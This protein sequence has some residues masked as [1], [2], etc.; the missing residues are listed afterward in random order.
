ME[1]IKP[2]EAEQVRLKKKNGKK[3]AEHVFT[4]VCITLCVILLPLFFVNLILTVKG[5][6]NQDEV[7]SLFSIAPM[8]VLT[9]SMVP[10]IDGG[11]L[12]F[13]KKVNPEDIVVDDIIAFFDPES[14][15]STMVVH[16]VKEISADEEGNLIFHTK[17]DAMNVYDTFII[18]GENVV[19]RYVFR[20]RG[21]GRFAMFL[22][23]TPGLIITVSVPLVMLFGY[24]GIRQLVY[25]QRERAHETENENE[26]ETPS[27]E[28]R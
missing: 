4:A 7:P 8:Y 18:T 11:D 9:D 26:P 28:S 22:Q 13:V 15:K 2:E 23:T 16:R 27:G 5:Y 19:G 17:G 12:I 21:L 24:E 14:L 20:L 25:L 1:Q 10:T 6:A 3:I